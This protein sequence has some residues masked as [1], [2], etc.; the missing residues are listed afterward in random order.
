MGCQASCVSLGDSDIL[1]YITR[2]KTI[3]LFLI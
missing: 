1:T 2:L 3:H